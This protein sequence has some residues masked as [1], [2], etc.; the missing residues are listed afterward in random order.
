[1]Y[2][3]APGRID[4]MVGADR[5]TA[6]FRA[7]IRARFEARCLEQGSGPTYGSFMAFGQS[8]YLVYKFPQCTAPSG[9]LV[10]RKEAA[11]IVTRNWFLMSRLVSQ[12]PSGI[13]FLL[14]RPSFPPFACDLTHTF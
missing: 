2:G 6:V 10:Q 4:S 12:N 8:I 7:D 11:H 9:R 5:K 1:V 13:P 3:Q 14:S